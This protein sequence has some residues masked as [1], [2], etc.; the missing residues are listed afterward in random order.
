MGLK[1]KNRELLPSCNLA[2]P[3]PKY[4]PYT[5]K[6]VALTLRDSTVLYIPGYLSGKC[7]KLSSQCQCSTPLD[8]HPDVGHILVHYLVT[9]TYQYLDTQEKSA[10]IERRMDEFTTSVHVYNAAKTYELPSLE[11]LAQAEM[12]KLGSGLS[13]PCVFGLV[14]KEYP[15]PSTNDAWLNNYLKT[16]LSSFLKE[17]ASP[18][19]VFLP[20]EECESITVSDILFKHLRE[21]VGEGLLV[22]RE[23]PKAEP[24]PEPPVLGVEVPKST[25]GSDVMALTPS[26]ESEPEPP[27][28]ASKVVDDEYPTP[29]KTEEPALCVPAKKSSSSRKG[30]RL[31]NKKAKRRDYTEASWMVRDQPESNRD[32]QHPT[33]FVL[34][35]PFG[36]DSE[37][38][39]GSLAAAIR[40][41][42]DSGTG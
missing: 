34:K 28:D 6:S 26:E 24:T 2:I 27:T 39:V 10:S 41:D 19:G 13:A 17:P 38:F 14:H 37:Y 1:K 7:P 23:L 29:T 15:K 20:G 4:S 12:E 18:P 3:Q 11:E 30:T 16:K 35:P 25:S 42:N 8:I 5:A 33:D 32:I 31:H 22:T 9:D 40:Q 21:L 36:Y